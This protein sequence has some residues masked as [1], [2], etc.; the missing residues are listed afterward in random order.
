MKILMSLMQLDIGGAET[1]VLELAKEL[2]RRGN[3][4]IITS[5]G[6]A[7]EKE[8]E[9]CGIKHYKVPLQNKN[10][11][12]VVTAFK[13]LKKIIID[14]KIEL[15][16]SHARI[17]SFILGK[18][19]KKMGFPFVTSAHGVFTTKY[20]L[21]YITDWGQATVAVSEDIKKY[22]LDNYN[23]PEKRI[24]VT[25]NG[26]DLSVF[27]P[28]TDKTPA[29]EEFGLSEDDFVIG[30]VSRLDVDCTKGARAILEKM[31]D[32]VEKI[33]NLKFLIVGG[34]T[35]FSNISALAD[36]VNKKYGNRVIM[37]GGRTD[38]A[39]VIS[40]CDLFVGVSRA[41]LE[42][43][44]SEKPVILAGNQ[45]YIGLFNEESADVSYATNFCGRGQA[46]IN[47]DTLF[48]EILKFYNLSQ[49]EKKHLGEY[50]RSFVEKHY[51][52]DKM[53]DDTLEAYDMVLHMKP[54]KEV[55][56]SGYY[57][58]KNSGDDALLKAITDDLKAK[59]PYRKIVVL[60][61]NPEETKKTYN[62]SAINRLNPFSV[63]SHMRKAELLI[64][65]GGTLIQDA[66]STKSLIYYLSVISTAKLLGMKVMLYAN[67]IGPVVSDKNKILTK[68]VLNKTDC[69]TLR[70]EKS[71][72]VL[73]ALGVT[74]PCIKI[75]AD[76]VFTIK[77]SGK[78]NGEKIL[79]RNGIPAG[80]KLLGI[81]L[82]YWKNQDPEFVKK[83][84]FSIDE[85][86]RKHSLFPVFLPLQP[87]D[88]EICENVAS[89]LNTKNVILTE[90]LF[91]DDMLSVIGNFDLAIGMRLHMLIY[92]AKCSV[93]IIGISYDPK[94]N[95]FMDYAKQDRCVFAE[96]IDENELIKNASEIFANYEKIK[97]ELILTAEKMTELAGE[98]L[99]FALSLLQEEE[100]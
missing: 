7:Y 98:N 4:I 44:A 72:E 69:I 64:S 39:S 94:I 9:M 62:V 84:A 34:G 1:H 3:E 53:T 16:H 65:G 91:I 11:M 23:Y 48:K 68:K 81:S 43:M 59:S 70:D 8:L 24:I 49:D 92:S 21:K 56:I 71:F 28:N 40:P 86:C 15:V 31:G 80:K 66:T 20:G 19:H 78:S 47:S 75:T 90:R 22:L 13:S 88:T 14:E 46:E 41:A 63:I 89:L 60:S 6:G 74:E 26:I 12:N 33:P 5:N 45:G 42:A 77:A 100:K 97:G 32:L 76:P 29:R 87:K 51:S 95:A 54:E 35:D 79:K 37:A 67:G 25:I 82:R 55:L 73:K 30:F 93:P 85:I 38:M 10:P 2:T 61:K 83:L 17:P 57:G 96:N 52:V 50:G 58:F 18:L 99:S 36:E 27:S